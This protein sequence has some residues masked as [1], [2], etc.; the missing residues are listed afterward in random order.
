MG[1]FPGKRDLTFPAKKVCVDSNLPANV[2]FSANDTIPLGTVLVHLHYG[3]FSSAVHYHRSGDTLFIGR[4]R[5][6][7]PQGGR[8]YVRNTGP[9][10]ASGGGVAVSGVVIGDDYADAY[11]RDELVFAPLS[12]SGELA[13]GN[14]RTRVHV[15]ITAHPSTEFAFS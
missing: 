15:V 5:A 1:I 4:P 12:G 13:G 2:V 10:F 9:A 14:P 3:W 6:V 8:V 7:R 11:P